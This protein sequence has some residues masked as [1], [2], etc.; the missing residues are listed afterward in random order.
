MKIEDTNIP[1]EFR[2]TIIPRPYPQTLNLADTFLDHEES[3]PA[4]YFEDER[5][6]Y[7]ELK[8]R[9]NQTARGLQECGIRDSDRIVLRL[10]NTP[11][12]FYTWLAINKLGA[13]VVPTL[14]AFQRKELEY[15]VQDCSPRAIITS[16]NLAE[17][18]VGL[19]ESIL[20]AEELIPK[21]FR[22]NSDENFVSQTEKDD[23]ALIVYTSGSTGKPKGTMHTHMELLSMVDI[24]APSHLR[25]Q[26]NDICSGTPS[27]A[28]VYGLEGLFAF[29]LRMGASTVL[30][31]GRFDPKKIE[32]AVQKHKISL[33][34]SG[35]RAY[36]RMLNEDIALGTSL[37]LCISAGEHLPAET[38]QKWKER[39]GVE[40]VDGIGCTELLSMLIAS[41]PGEVRPGST[42]KAV[43]GYEIRLLN[44]EGREVETN[45]PGLLSVRGPTGCWYL[46]KPEEQKA[47]VK[48]GWTNTGDIFTRDTE[49]YFYYCGRNDDLINIGGNKVYPLE[50]E[51]VLLTHQEI[52]EAAVVGLRK[53]DKT[54]LKAYVVT[55][56]NRRVTSE[57]LT[58]LVRGNLSYYKVPNEI[59]FVG[60]LPKTPNGKLA[61]RELSVIEGNHDK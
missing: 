26:Q 13:I 42:G 4:I 12:F 50:V 10:E 6:S 20:I 36:S 38:Y 29:P 14:P 61:R 58:A 27:M 23:V 25:L 5:I 48:D 45:T 16:Q 49:G 35:P 18:T 37:R 53:G 30:L 1:L 43:P 44:P 15:I 46:N 55:K 9:V 47:R 32:K 40:I 3:M 59:I 11:Y 19:S 56:P 33:L 8:G 22:E 7:G 17:Q 54:I 2:P 60:S 39:F 41:K 21:W 34:F 31:A 51:G 57:E 28:F 52:E 24:Y